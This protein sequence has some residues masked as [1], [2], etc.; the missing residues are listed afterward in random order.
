MYLMNR[1]IT[2]FLDFKSP[3]HILYNHTL[4]SF[5]ENHRVLIY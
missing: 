3:Y 5:Y 2:P 1:L 4:L